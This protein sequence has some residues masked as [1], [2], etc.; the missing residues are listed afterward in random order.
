MERGLRSARRELRAGCR[1]TLRR[2]SA[3]DT[4]SSDRRHAESKRRVHL[5]RARELVEGDRDVGRRAASAVIEIS[6]PMRAESASVDRATARIANS[7]RRSRIACAAPDK[8]PLLRQSRS[9]R[10]IGAKT[11][12][13]SGRPTAHVDP[14]VVASRSTSETRRRGSS[15]SGASRSRSPTP[16]SRPLAPTA[17]SRVRSRTRVFLPGLRRVPTLEI[18]PYSSETFSSSPPRP[19]RSREGDCAASR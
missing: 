11:S 15:S 3:I 7:C 10:R 17:A 19:A 6:C 8:S 9:S 18:T 4:C 5:Q 16:V 2:T 13:E 1:E 12:R 14:R